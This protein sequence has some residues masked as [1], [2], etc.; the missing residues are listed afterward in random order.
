MDVD[1]EYRRRAGAEELKKIAPKRFNPE[2]EAWL[3][4][5]HAE[6]DGWNFTALCSNAARAHD[7]GKTHD[8]VVLYYDR[9]GEENQATVVTETHGS[10]EGKRVVRGREAEC[11]EY[12]AS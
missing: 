7:L 4:I 3:P 12:Y 2:G 9:G 11:R 1:A 6:R 5:M 10:L 8:W